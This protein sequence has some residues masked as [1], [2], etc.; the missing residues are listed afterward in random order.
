M[1]GDVDDVRALIAR[2]M[3][4][5]PHDDAYLA[6]AVELMSL[7]ADDLE[8]DEAWILEDTAG[9]I[10][11]YRISITG[12]SA[13][14]EELHLEPDRIGHGFGRM[15]F[16]HARGRAKERGVTRLEWSCDEY[17]LGFYLAMGGQITG[18][19]PSGVTGDEPLT[20]MALVL[21]SSTVAEGG[22]SNTR[23]TRSRTRPDRQELSRPPAA[24][25]PS[26]RAAAQRQLR[27]GG[28][29]HDEIQRRPRGIPVSRTPTP[30]EADP[31]AV[32][33]TASPTATP[34]SSSADG[35]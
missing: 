18:S 8:R 29:Q 16:E 7:D 6:Q 34:G 15:L 19:I 21:P 31:D 3:G 33:P 4:H 28:V 22:K 11:F 2:S 10:G 20:A 24:P 12:D 32:V 26:G 25:L 23:V 30:R 5:W 1:A 9:A 27:D 17:A 13:E 35:W 14:I